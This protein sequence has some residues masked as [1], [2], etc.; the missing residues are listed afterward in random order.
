MSST[1][2]A[3][4]LVSARSCSR[5]NAASGSSSKKRTSE[6]LDAGQSDSAQKVAK[7][8]PFFAKRVDSPQTG[9]FRWLDPLGPS[10]S[11]LHGINLSPR[12]AVKV[13]AFD[14][15]GTL[16]K[17]EFGNKGSPTSPSWEWWRNLIPTKLKEVYDSGYSIL[18]ISNQALKPQALKTWK[19]KI[20]SIAAALPDVPFRL[21]AATSK[22]N[23][24]KPMPGMWLEL[25]R[26]FREEGV[27]IDKGASFFVGDAAGR[28]YA[29]RKSDFSS[30]DRKW[31]L[32]I[33]ITFYTPEEYFLKLPP[34][35]SYSLPG[36][37]VLSLPELP[38]VMPTSTPLLPSPPRQEIVL[39]V[40]YP[41]LGKTSFYRRHFQP[42]GYTHINQDTL[43]TRD[44]CVKAMRE[45][46][47]QDKSCVIDNTNRDAA[48]R[49]FYVDVAKQLNIP[50][51]C[52]L[53]TGS[54]ELAWHNNLYRTYNL[55]PSVAAQEPKRELVPSIAYTGFR[56]NYEEPKLEEGFDEIKKVNW[57]FSG[58]EEEKNY[59][60]MWLQLD[61]K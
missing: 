58:T 24:R 11:C 37:H 22:D 44:K 1:I 28:L 36:F 46:L 49:K 26:I 7:V 39:F 35:T 47:R 8:H 18:I 17:S 5:L 25:E 21:F 12:A 57:V 14:L 13:A 42:A 60:S 41:S 54:F 59:W 43:K 38:Q 2:K 6:H 33:G 27:D 40:G 56:N 10:R 45:A 9:A 52:F 53:F 50:I 16:I 20:T 55:P 31:A 29:G 51:R 15:D 3:G 30:T 19:L 23:Y 34:H 48:T 61:G 4:G 32:N